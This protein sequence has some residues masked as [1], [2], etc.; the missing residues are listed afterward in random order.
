VFRE[1]ANNS[2]G[3]GSFYSEDVYYITN[4]AATER[5]QHVYVSQ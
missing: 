2:S 3:V 1:G 4:M 5:K